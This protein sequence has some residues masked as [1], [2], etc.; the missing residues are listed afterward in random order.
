[1]LSSIVW[2]FLMPNV[3]YSIYFH[4]RKSEPTD[5]AT[6]SVTSTPGEPKSTEDIQSQPSKTKVT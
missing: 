6:S 4:N 3:T 5:Q 1:M 2:A